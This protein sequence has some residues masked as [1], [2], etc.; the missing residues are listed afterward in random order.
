[1]PQL[2]PKE[3]WKRFRVYP[4]WDWKDD[5]YEKFMLSILQ[6]LEVRNF[7]KKQYIFKELE[8]CHEVYFIQKGYYNVGY[9]INKINKYRL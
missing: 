4:F 3:P 6:A 7:D 1:M 2:N 8:E 5:Q 9:E